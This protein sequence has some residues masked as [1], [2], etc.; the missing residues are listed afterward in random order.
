MS[1]Y[2]KDLVSGLNKVETAIERINAFCSGK[3]TLVAFSGGK[4]SQC[5]YHLAKMAGIEFSAQYSIT[6]F[7][8]PELIEFIRKEYPDVAFRRAYKKSLVEE[9]GENGLPNRFYRW[10]CEAKHKKTEGFDIA[11]IGIRWEE[12]A[13]RKARWSMFGTKKDRSAYICPICDWTTAD[14]WEFLNSNR[15]PH[16]C[17]YDEGM[18][19]IGCVCC[20]LATR[21]MRREAKRWP[22]TAAM[23][24]EGHRKNWDKCVRAGGKTKKGGWYKMIRD[25]KTPEEAF[26]FWLENGVTIKAKLDNEDLPCL[27]AGTGFSESDGA[28]KGGEE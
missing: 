11:V 15:I 17:L 23:L 4:D 12:S 9:I 22:K 8:P 24:L 28:E 14:V 10:C 20:P 21:H 18:K 1:I 26:D 27:F 13:R 16:C 7:E 25:F 6:R 5:C 3:K 19:R 2:E